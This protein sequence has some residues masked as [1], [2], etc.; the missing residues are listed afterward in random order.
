MNPVTIAE[1]MSPRPYYCRTTDACGC[2]ARLMWEHDCGALPVVDPKGFPVG[3]ITD[4]DIC[5]AA[6]TQGKSLWEIPVTTACSAHLYA[7]RPDD[8]VA[9]A[10]E[11]MRRHRV[12]RLA[13]LD[14][15]HNLLGVISIG[16]IL[17]KL[18]FAGRLGDTMD[19]GGVVSMLAEVFRPGRG[20]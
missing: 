12:R 10:M 2:A 9:N 20:D 7:V 3:M 8:L 18:E 14:R 17:K 4:R 15:G 5:M 6:Y 19:R 16:D 11:L 13:V 1:I